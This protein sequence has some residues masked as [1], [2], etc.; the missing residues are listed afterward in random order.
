[1]VFDTHKV[2]IF[3]VVSFIVIGV[4]ANAF[5]TEHLVWAQLLG[6][7][8]V[9]HGASNL[10]A[11]KLCCNLIGLKVAAGITKATAETESAFLPACFKPL[12]LTRLIKVEN[13][14]LPA[15][16]MGAE[17][18]KH[19]LIQCSEVAVMRFDFLSIVFVDRTIVSRNGVIRRSLKDR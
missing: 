16:L 9:G 18:S 6:S 19:L 7:L 1:M 3:A 8:G 10:V 17:C 2:N 14:C 13:G 5:A 12:R 15:G 11:N 4:N